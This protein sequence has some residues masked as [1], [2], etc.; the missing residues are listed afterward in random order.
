MGAAFAEKMVEWVS[1]GTR[2]ITANPDR[3]RQ[4]VAAVRDVVESQETL[5]SVPPVLRP[6]KRFRSRRYLA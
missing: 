2:L 4:I 5:A 6:V 1:L 3:Y